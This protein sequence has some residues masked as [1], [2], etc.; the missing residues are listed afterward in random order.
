M[1]VRPTGGDLT[2]AIA[3]LGV[4]I[5]LAAAL[6]LVNGLHPGPVLVA[7]GA[8]VIAAGAVFDIPFPVQPLKALTALAVAQGLAP[9][10][11]HA[12][13]LQIGVILTVLALLGLA[14]RLARFFTLPVIRSL[15]FA[16]GVLLVVSATRLVAN[17]PEL[18]DRPPGMPWSLTLGALTAVVVAVAA[19]R[20]WYALIGG[21]V[22]AGVAAG[23]ASAGLDLGPPAVHLPGLTLPPPTVFWSAFVLLVVPQIPLTYSNAVVG[24]SHLA[25]QHF[26]EQARRVTPGRV[27]LTCGVGNVAAAAMGGMPMCH[28]SSGLTAHVRLGARTPAMNLVLGGTF[29]VLGVGFADQVLALFSVLP[30]WA[31]AGFLAYAGI[32][33][34]LLVA[35]LRRIRLAVALVAGLIGVVTGNLALTTLVALA[36]EHGGAIRRRRRSRADR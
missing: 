21:L 29:V 36:A 1:R 16:V 3:D 11:I 23:V 33:H 35:D 19:A 22:V 15:Q 34:A 10:T 30:A 4:L 27:A 14:D 18:L 7:A 5:P 9:E 8:L 31:L 26:G 20:R 13:G 12:A 32:R 24:V 17:P 6:V 28:G 2:G 25:R